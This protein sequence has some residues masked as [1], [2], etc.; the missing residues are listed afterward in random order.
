MRFLLTSEFVM[1]TYLEPNQAIATAKKYLAPLQVEAV[2]EDRYELLRLWI[3][4]VP[5]DPIERRFWST[6]EDMQRLCIV[7][8]GSLR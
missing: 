2:L 3:D 5:I 6:H 1:S 8:R 4:G 7:L